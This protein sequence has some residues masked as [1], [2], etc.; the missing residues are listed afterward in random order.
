M[1]RPLQAR[2]RLKPASI[3]RLFV[4]LG[5]ARSSGTLSDGAGRCSLPF[6]GAWSTQGSAIVGAD[7]GPVQYP[8]QGSAD[9]TRYTTHAPP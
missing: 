5:S 2:G 9:H 4:C 7:D 1:Q 8:V 3:L 6:P